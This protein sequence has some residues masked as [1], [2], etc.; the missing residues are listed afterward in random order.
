MFNLF[1][2]DDGHKRQT[3]KIYKVPYCVQDTIPIYRISR[4]GIFELENKKGIHLF[5]KAYLFEDINFAIQDEEEQDIT[6]KKFRALL[7]AMNVSYKIIISNH[8]ADNKELRKTILHKAVSE[9]LEPL[10]KEYHKLIEERL[11]EGREGLMQSRY[12]IITCERPDF[13]SAKNYFNTIESTLNNHFMKVGSSL[14]PLDCGDRLRALHSFYRMGKEETFDFNWDEYV[15]LRR[16]WRNDI[17]NTSMTEYEDRIEMEEGKVATTLFIRKWPAGLDYL[18]LKE[19]TNVPFPVIVSLD[20]EPMDNSY[21]YNLVNRKYMNN[22]RAIIAQ[23][24]KKNDL[25]DYSSDISFEKEMKQKESREL[26]YSLREYDNRLFYASLTVLIKAD[27][28][29]ELNA[30]KEKIK[31]IAQGTYNMELESYSWNQLD[32]MNTTLP[33]GARFIDNMRSLTTESLSIFSPFNVQEINHEYGYCYGVNTVS[34]NLILGNRKT[35]DNGNGMVFGKSGSGKSFQEKMEMGQTLC[36]TKDDIVVIDPMGE[37]KEIAEQWKGQYVNLSQSEENVFYINPLH[38]PENIPDKERFI[39]EK[40]EFAYAICEQ[41]LKPTALTSRHIA[42][43]DRAIRA[44]YDTY[45]KEYETTKPKH[46]S[47]IPSPTLRSMREFM[48]ENEPDN[49][50]AKELV[51]QLEVFTNGTLDIFAR[52]QS[53]S[54]NNRFTVYGFSELGKR[55][56]TMAMLVMIES[57]TAKIKYNQTTGIHTWVYVDEIHEIWSDEYAL[58]AIERM[59]REVRKRG[60]ICTGMSQNLV[61]ALSSRSTKTIVSNSEF[62]L[63]LDQG[64][65]DRDIVSEL[66]TVSNEQISKVE[67][68]TQG[69]GLVRFGKKIVPFDNT[70]S[71]ENDLYKLFNTNFSE[72]IEN[73]V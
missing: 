64:V 8:Y 22:E 49:E 28:I 14:T 63:L 57:I 71:K 33:T 1:K 2:M 58:L 26:L 52:Q 48:I 60:G 43:I 65:T 38:V 7:N 36:F 12:F 53:T 20:C 69:T 40:A 72:L 30:R 66:F 51:E 44:I 23:Q 62:T 32:A 21:A 56:R 68:A 18:F 39:A 5:D 55:M 54:E 73:G 59:W 16:D 42:I 13:E 45:F 9:E 24:Q 67:G 29:E 27:S 10:A 34:K 61:D 17:I 3:E 19:L 4:E 41:A 6:M 46:R 25:N 47:E 11:E 37:Y 31:I 50:I 35:M 70:V 15:E